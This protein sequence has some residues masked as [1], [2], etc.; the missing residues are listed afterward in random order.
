MGATI[1]NG[2]VSGSLKDDT[3]HAWPIRQHVQP[4]ARGPMGTEHPDLC[5]HTTET[6]SYV[7]TLEFPSQWQTGEGVIGQHIR[8]G[9]AGDA[10]NEHDAT[11]EQIEM[12]GRSKLTKWLPR[13]DTLGPTVALVAWLHSTGRIR[14]GLKR[15]NAAWPLVLD[16]LPAAVTSYYRRTDGTWQAPGVY[17]HVEIPANDHYDPG[18]FDYPTFFAR[19]EKAIK[20]QAG[21]KVRYRVG[22]RTFRRLKRA[23]A[24]LRRKLRHSKIGS[25]LRIRKVGG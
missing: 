22:E 14:T 17:G 21:T 7:T 2:L 25:R 12:V 1:A 23:L 9:L 15:P 10:V 11:L 18:S 5:L 13:E 6:D 24:Y 3:G 19:V 20:V 8:V 16:K 4:S